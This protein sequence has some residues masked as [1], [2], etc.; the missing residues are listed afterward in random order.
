ML[1]NKVVERERQREGGRGGGGGSLWKKINHVI[2][3]SVAVGSYYLLSVFAVHQ[4][5]DLSIT[6]L[7]FYHECRSYVLLVTLLTIH[8]YRGGAVSVKIEDP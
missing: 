8:W 3:I 7:A 4:L 5:L 2:L 6:P 1:L